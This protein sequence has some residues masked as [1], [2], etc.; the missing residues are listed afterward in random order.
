MVENN[1]HTFS[2]LSTGTLTQLEDEV[3]YP[4]SGLFKALVQMSKG[5]IVVKN[6][7]NDF[8][9]TQASSG[10]VIQVS[11]GTY[12]RDGKLFTASAAN[13][14]TSAFTTTYDKGYHM[15]VVNSS[16][17][18]AIRQPTAADRVPNYTTGD[19]IIALIEIS[20]TTPYG[21]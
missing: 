2:K 1:P 8:D 6:D 15:L 18:L 13:F 12:F 17:A 5:N 11:A 4:H 19:T 3:D 20:S 14:T 7:S 10:N 16:N 21:S 9:I